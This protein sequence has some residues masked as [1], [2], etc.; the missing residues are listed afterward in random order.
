MT[1]TQESEHRPADSDKAGRVFTGWLLVFGTLATGSA[2]LLPPYSLGFAI[3]GVTAAIVGFALYPSRRRLVWS[4]I[5]QLLGFWWLFGLLL[6]EGD[7]YQ[8]FYD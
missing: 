5:S 6:V 2:L 8:F 3:G 4:L 1:K 7:W